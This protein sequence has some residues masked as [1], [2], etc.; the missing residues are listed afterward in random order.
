M[1]R[2][3]F[4][5]D[6]GKADAADPARGAG[7]ILLHENFGE[8]NRVED[9]CATVRLIGRDTHLRHDFQQ[10]LADR[11]DVTLDRLRSL[12]LLRERHR[13]VADRLE[14]EMRIDGLR[15]VPREER[16]MMHFACFP[17]LDDET[18]G[19]P[20]SGADQVMMHGG[21]RQQRRD[22]NP[23]GTHEPVRQ[24]DD[25]VSA[26]HGLI[27]ARA[28]T[29]EGRGH[30]VRAAL[31]RI[32]DVEGLGVEAVLERPDRADLLE[33]LVSEDR[34]TNLETLFLRVALVIEN[35]R[36]RADE[37]HEAHH[38]FLADRIDRRVRHLGEILLEIG[39]EELRFGRERRDRRIRAHRSRG[40]HAGQSHR[41]H[42]DRQVLLRVAE[43]LLSIEQRNVAAGLTGFDARQILQH[44]L[45]SLDPLGIGMQTGQM[46]LDLTVG[47]DAPLLE[48]DQQHLARLQAPLSNDLF[49]RDR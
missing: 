30:P 11:L 8:T 24:N 41:R 49:F 23:I 7:E 19:R 39:I 16:E 17:R 31:G 37:R 28:Q 9:L 42:Q 32:S 13:H 45:C 3:A 18:D 21:R 34:L 14:G 36:A 2:N 12:D 33:V 25:V 22:R 10:A 4:L 29:I 1:T 35:V 40:F 15:A 38:E 47:D 46:F 44:D 48:I 43:R 27:G 5:G 6:F 20:K 26:L